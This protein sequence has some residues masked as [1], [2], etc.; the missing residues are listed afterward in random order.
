MTSLRKVDPGGAKPL[1]LGRD[2][3]DDQVDAVPAPGAGLPPVGHRPAGR[4]LRPGEQQPEPAADDLRKGRRPVLAQLE[5]EMAGVEVD[6][7][8]D[9]VDHVAD[10][11]ELLGQA[12]ILHSGLVYRRPR[13]W[14]SP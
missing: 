8:V 12:A 4:A 9:V 1:G 7:R 10:V 14:T 6:R 2:V 13:P 11:H 3:V 5:P